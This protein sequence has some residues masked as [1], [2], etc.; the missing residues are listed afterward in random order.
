MSLT[1]GHW[2]VIDIA[3]D[4]FAASGHPPTLRKLTKSTPVEIK[5][6]YLCTTGQNSCPVVLIINPGLI[7]DI[8]HTIM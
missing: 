8:R 1:D 2:L 4:E 6:V 5:Q 7:C 3:Q